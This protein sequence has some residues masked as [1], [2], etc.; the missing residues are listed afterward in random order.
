MADVTAE[1]RLLPGRLVIVVLNFPAPEDRRVWAL[2][3]AARD[4]GWSVDVISPALR[5]H[6]PGRGE[7]DGIGLQWFRP[8]E[9][10]GGVGEAVVGTAAAARAVRARKLG[11][12]DVLHVCTPPDSHGP[13]LAAH[14]RR[15]VGTLYD[16]HDVVPLLAAEKAGHRRI[17]RLYDALERA[18]VRASTVVVTAGRVQADRLR[19]LYGTEAVVVRTAAPL[20]GR[21]HDPPE[22]A[23]VRYFAS[24]LSGAFS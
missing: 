13:L 14:K 7:Q 5:G 18:T 19:E 1:E 17:R 22:R 6:R 12:G 15:G 8:V 16:Q 23:S 24:R 21:A 11:R 2:A 4:A 20:L 9:R 10:L 3:T